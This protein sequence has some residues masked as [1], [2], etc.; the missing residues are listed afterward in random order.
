MSMNR[1][2]MLRNMEGFSGF[3][4]VNIPNRPVMTNTE[5][6]DHAMMG[7]VAGL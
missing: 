2:E 6:Y 1:K 5:Q 7:F 4:S 3:C